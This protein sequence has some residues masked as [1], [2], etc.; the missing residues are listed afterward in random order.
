MPQAKGV[1][2]RRDDREVLYKNPQTCGYFVAVRL[3]PGMDR[4]ALEAWLGRTSGLVEALVA[5]EP[6]AAGQDKGRKVAAVAIG[7]APR[8]FSLPGA[9]GVEPPASF[10]PGAQLPTASGPLSQAPVLDAD[11][12]FYVA[13]VQ[14]ARVHEFVTALA[15]PGAGVVG[16]R[17]ERGYQRLDETEPFGYKDGVRN[18]LPRADRPRIAFVHRDGADADEPEWADGGSYLAYVKIRQRPE[19][20]AA[21]PDDAARDAA[22]GRTRDGK[23]LDVPDS[24]TAPRD[25]PADASALPPSSHVRKTGPRGPHDAVQVFRRGLPYVETTPAGEV[26]VG[27]HF[28]SFQASLEQFD[29]M[30]NDWALNPRFPQPPA[31]HPDPGPDA[32]LDPARGLTANEAVGFFFVPPHHPDGLAAAVLRPPPPAGGKKPAAGRLV[33]RKRITDPADPAKRFERAGF[34]F[35]VLDAQ[36]AAVAG[37]DMTTDLTGRAVCP[38]DLPLGASYTLEETSAPIPV[39]ALARQQF[40][41]DKPNQQVRVDNAAAAGSPY[42]AQ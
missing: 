1:L 16:A 8:F 31:G 40:V 37:S 20:F 12:M 7:L 25:E 29:V 39:Q 38:A 41:M 11:A 32:L 34:A 36:G 33:V 14:E 5:R 28:A 35:R 21:L 3:D 2:P 18:A 19:V 9:A 27:L 23:R 15:A 24:R 6:A 4:V 10:A 30:Y 42:G 22:I 17:M 26:A 13:S